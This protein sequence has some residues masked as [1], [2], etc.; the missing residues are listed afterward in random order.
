MNY[1]KPEISII[2]PVF[3]AEKSLSRC[4]ES[5]INQTYPNWELLL[6]DDGSEDDSFAVSKSL[7]LND[8]RI[9]LLS[10]AHQGV[11][12]ARNLA[13][14]HAKGKY[15]C[16]IDSDDKVEPDYLESLYN[17]RFYDMVICGYFVD[18]YNKEREMIK[19]EEYIPISC[20]LTSFRQR[21]ELLPLFMSGMIHSNWNK[22]FKA[23]IISN[24][25]LRYISVPVNEDYLFMID[26]L[27]HCNS[28]ITINKPLYH[29]IRNEGEKT[30]VDSMPDNLLE[31]YNLAQI[32]TREF[33]GDYLIADSTQYYS[34]CYIIQKY[35]TAYKQGSIDYRQLSKNL[36][37]FHKNEFVKASFNAYQPKSKGEWL[38][39]SLLKYGWFHTYQFVN[40]VLSL[41]RK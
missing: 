39:H 4:V 32:K 11:A 8:E 26:Y 17:Y 37:A 10:Q 16:M 34:Y 36:S 35:F 19:Q 14:T 31:I 30:G 22:L 25:Q 40:K 27:K 1:I 15:I 13:I 9:R 18:K 20:N 12:S 3:N 2:V 23:S 33:Y 5:I 24:N 28:L 29:W 6:I 7:S 41:W 38:L 21:N